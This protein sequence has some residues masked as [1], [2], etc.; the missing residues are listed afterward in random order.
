M[1][2]YILVNG[3]QEL[4]TALEVKCGQ[5]DLGMKDTGNLIKLMV[6]VN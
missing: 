3:T 1:G 4:E 5:M 2:L 6:K